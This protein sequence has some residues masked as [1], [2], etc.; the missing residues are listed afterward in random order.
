MDSRERLTETITV[1]FPP[2]ETKAIREMAQRLDLTYTGV[3]R[4]AVRNLAR[5]SQ[6]ETITLGWETATWEAGWG[7]KPYGN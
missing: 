3:V 7:A 4:Q 2:D 5:Q 1:C 6:S